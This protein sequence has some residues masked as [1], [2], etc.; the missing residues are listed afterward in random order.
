M[1]ENSCKTGDLVTAFYK[2]GK[3]IGEITDD[4]RAQSYVVRVLAVEKHPM[5]GD[6][7]NPK[8]ADVLMF[9]QRRALAFREQTNVPRNM[10]KP[11]SGTVPSYEQSLKDSVARA[12]EELEGKDDA[13]SK[14]SLESLRELEKEYS[15]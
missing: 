5:Q 8:E 4:S 1:A 3:Y 14:K 15:Y 7:H 2:T 10:V 13:W 12:M 9:H 11:F 6:L